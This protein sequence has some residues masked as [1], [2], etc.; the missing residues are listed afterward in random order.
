M[1]ILQLERISHTELFQ[2]IL[3]DFPRELI[4]S[5][6]PIGEGFPDSGRNNHVVLAIEKIRFQ[7]LRRVTQFEHLIADRLGPGSSCCAILT[8][9]LSELDRGVRIFANHV[10]TYI[11]PPFL[12]EDFVYE[13]ENVFIFGFGKVLL[14]VL[15]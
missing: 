9:R 5:S 11:C 4:R 13:I 8:C 14:E 6:V 15:L 2:R 7:A 12:P 3:D 1:E 10:N